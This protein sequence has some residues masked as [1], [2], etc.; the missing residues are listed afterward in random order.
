MATSSDGSDVPGDKPVR[1]GDAPWVAAKP[2]NDA[3]GT[4][5]V[6]VG[7]DDA[8]NWD[9]DEEKTSL[10]SGWRAVGKGSDQVSTEGDVVATAQTDAAHEP[11]TMGNAALLGLG[12]FGGVFLLYAV[13]WFIA[14]GRMEYPAIMLLNGGLSANSEALLGTMMFQ[15]LKWASILAPAV[16]FGVVFVLTRTSRPWVRFAW[17]AAGAFL[18]IPWPMLLSGA[19]MG[20]AA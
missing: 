4:N 9:G 13:G 11:Q 2:A 8:L 19:S 20:G 16:W 7:D 5:D 3:A 17:L 12:I 1:A 14:A 6:H 10:P 18:L 15:I